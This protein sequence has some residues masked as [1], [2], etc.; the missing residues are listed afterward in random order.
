MPNS[1][2]E[3]HITIEAN[4]T[5]EKVSQLLAKGSGLSLQQI[6]QAMH[7]GAVW[8]ENSQGIR[9]IRRADS[10]I[11]DGN[12][13]HFYY[14][15][16]VLATEP[17]TPQLVADEHDYSLW[18]KPT[19]ML[20]QGS[21]WADHFTINRWIESHQPFSHNAQ[22]NAFIVHRLDKAACGLI[23]IAHT[24]KATQK[25]AALFEHKK[26]RK[27]Y[28]VIV[29]GDF[30][31]QEQIIEA[32]IEG[33]SAHTMAKKIAFDDDQQRSLLDVTIK[34]GRK[35]QIRIHMSQLGHP[36]VGDRLHGNAD[37]NAPDLQLQSFS[38]SFT[39]PISDEPKHY[40]C[41]KALWL[42]L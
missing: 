4:D 7:K 6:K 28:R 36:V 22:R 42:A 34:T 24:K 33:K 13:L 14:A 18:Y 10:K 39:C 12:I 23:L 2:Q 5:G 31:D 37:K 26:I 11:R 40:Q 1:P 41:P 30:G 17:P 19:G 9:R 27:H 25:L 29:D 35:H 15:P 16:D 32:D 3:F 38:L 8:L 21:K 20:C